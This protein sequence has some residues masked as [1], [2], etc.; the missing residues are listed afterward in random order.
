MSAVS[1]SR[2]ERWGE[3]PNFLRTH[4]PSH[5][6]DGDGRGAHPACGRLFH[7]IG[8]LES[9]SGGR[10]AKGVVRRLR[11]IGFTRIHRRPEAFGVVA[12]R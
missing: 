11:E 12:A 7:Y 2:R 10:V 8:D 5:Q 4:Q 1:S 3:D 6:L 9:R